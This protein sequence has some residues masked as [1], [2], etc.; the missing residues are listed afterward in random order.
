MFQEYSS[1]RHKEADDILQISSFQN[2]SGK[3]ETEQLQK[4]LAQQH[5][6]FKRSVLLSDTTMPFSC[7]VSEI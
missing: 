7:V 1:K 4:C 3:H 2:K 5:N 6:L